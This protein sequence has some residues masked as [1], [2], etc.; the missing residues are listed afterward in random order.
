VPWRLEVESRVAGTR[1]YFLHVLEIGDEQDTMMSEVSLIEQDTSLVGVRIALAETETVEV[2]FSRW[3][4]LSARVKFEEEALEYLPTEIDTTLELGGRGDLNLDGRV[5]ITDVIYLILG[6]R[7]NPDEERF[8]FNR[9]GG[10]SMDDAIALILY[11]RKR[12]TWGFLAAAS[13]P[14]N[15]TAEE[16]KYIWSMLERLNLSDSERSQALALL[17][18]PSLAK[19]LALQ[20]NSPNPFN[21]STTISY[22]L[23]NGPLLQTRV[24]IYNLRGQ[25]VRVLVDEVKEPGVYHVF[26]DGTDSQGREVPSGVYFY[27]LKAGSLS[28]V[29]K[30]IVLR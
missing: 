6:A 12:A 22:S 28:R 3:G 21:P 25:M 2:Y 7:E 4:T 15:F 14:L 20:Q 10:Y 17:G 29:R 24:E 27:R 23:P 11:I 19:E 30:M 1:D 18:P 8:D 9:D 26:W 13:E 16:R 5:S